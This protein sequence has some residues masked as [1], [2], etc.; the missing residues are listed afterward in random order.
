MKYN[1]II[2]LRR[3]HNAF[4][5]ELCKA[6]ESSQYSFVMFLKTLSFNAFAEQVVTACAMYPRSYAASRDS[7]TDLSNGIVNDFSIGT[8][9]LT[10]ENY[11]SLTALVLEAGREVMEA[12]RAVDYFRFDRN[13]C[14]TLLVDEDEEYDTDVTATCELKNTNRYTFLV[15]IQEY[16]V[17][18]I[19]EDLYR[20]SVYTSEVLERRDH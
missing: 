18:D 4:H 14:R 10:S 8:Y 20:N 7:L 13:R 17:S 16:N 3:A 12:L 5:R 19:D 2:R 15:S 6:E 9:R 1:F 11:D